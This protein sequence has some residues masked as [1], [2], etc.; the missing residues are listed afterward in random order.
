MRHRGSFFR[1]LPRPGKLEVVRVCPRCRSIYATRVQWCGID[2]TALVDQPHD[3]LIGNDLERY[4]I[5]EN[6]GVGGMG[7]VYRASHAFIEREY[8]IKVL[9]GDFAGDPKFRERFRRE[10][11]S[12]SQIRHPNIVTVEDFGTTPEGLTFLAMELVHGRTLE[13][14]IEEEAPFSPV[15]AAQIVRQVVAGLGAAHSLGFIH[16]DV[17]PSN[18]MLSDQQGLELVKILDFGAVSMR[19]V[20]VDQRLT[21]IGHIIGTPTYMAPEQSQDPNVGPPADLYAVG[22]ILYEMLT[23]TA[24]F[25]G[26]G[27]AEVLIKH[28]MEEPPKAPPSRGLERLVAGLLKKQPSDRPQAALE[29]IRMIDM[30]GLDLAIVSDPPRKAQSTLRTAEIPGRGLRVDSGAISSRI[31][32]PTMDPADQPTPQSDRD[33]IGYD[34]FPSLGPEDAAEWADWTHEGGTMRTDLEYEFG[35]PTIPIDSSSLDRDSGAD[36]DPRM[37]DPAEVTDDIRETRPFDMRPALHS[38]Q[39]LPEGGPVMIRDDGPTQVDFSLLPA[40]QMPRVTTDDM[41]TGDLDTARTL[42]DDVGTSPGAPTIRDT[43]LPLDLDGPTGDL[44]PAPTL[45]LPPVL[46]ARSGKALAPDSARGGSL[47]APL[48]DGA[49]SGKALAPDSARGGSLRA[50]LADGARSGRALAP[51]SARGGS[52]RAPL[53]DGARSGRALAPDSARGGSLRAPLADGARSGRALAPDSARGG[54]LRARIVDEG[55]KGLANGDVGS[56]DALAPGGLAIDRGADF[57]EDSEESLKA[58][59]IPVYESTT[60]RAAAST[61]RTVRTVTLIALVFLL[62]MVIVSVV[63]WFGHTQREPVVIDSSAQSSVAPEQ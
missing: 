51:D 18:I 30:L 61:A 48:A 52:L 50:P 63:L 28:I 44:P 8:A 57:L 45:E 62:S 34:T 27:R 41:P 55:G 46:G 14:A 39:D 24:P 10:A 23:G 54:S 16:R 35:G 22:V 40:L 31:A 47:R 53:A 29:V 59:V 37:V 6:L 43:E 19:S 4:R 36:T 42:S 9:F 38:S 33:V 60:D 7:C 25:V 3:P 58:R 56:G 13:Q 11:K 15:R 32:A 5:V 1:G 17:K 2:N 21:S 26:K 20:P 49:R 12:I